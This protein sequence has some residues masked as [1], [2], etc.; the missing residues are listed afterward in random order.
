MRTRSPADADLSKIT[1]AA[2]LRRLPKAT[3]VPRPTPDWWDF[4]T[5]K[6]ADAM[7]LGLPA[8]PQEPGDDEPSTGFGFIHGDASTG[9]RVP[10]FR[11]VEP[12]PA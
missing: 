3:S 2:V 8:G 5:S 6:L 9:S 1:V 12:R 10:H 7:G 11:R 4:T